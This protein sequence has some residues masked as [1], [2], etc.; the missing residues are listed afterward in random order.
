[1]FYRNKRKRALHNLRKLEELSNTYK[2]DFQ[3]D[4]LSLF[5]LKK[6][7]IKTLYDVSI[8]LNE[9]RNIPKEYLKNIRE[10]INRVDF[11][12]A[13]DFDKSEEGGLCTY[14]KNRKIEKTGYIASA[15]GVAAG[16]TS[17]LG[18]STISMAIATTFGTA[19][20]GVAISTLSGAALNSA[21]LAWLGGG[22]LAAGGGGMA[23]GSVLISALTG[24]IGIGLVVIS[25]V[26]GS[27]IYAKA[28]KRD[29]KEIEIQSELI[30]KNTK[31]IK[32]YGRKVKML[33]RCISNVIMKIKT[34]LKDL[35]LVKEW[36]SLIENDKAKL[37]SLIKYSK[38]LSNLM[39]YRIKA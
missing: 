35:D 24:P 9:V 4:I 8:Y 25:V 23:A 21:A 39:N 11:F 26:A 33:K 16:G 34:I 37:D 14:K 2:D 10:I 6:R 12:G 38:A 17:I 32:E 36:K 7:A 1:M 3:A 30:A 19:S 27:S 29:T 22:A 18:G 20:T 13:T 15:L 28:N 5:E 31:K